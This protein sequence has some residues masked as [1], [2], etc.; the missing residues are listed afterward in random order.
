[1]SRPRIACVLVAS[2]ALGCAAGWLQLPAAQ[3]APAAKA[4]AKVDTRALE[5]QLRSKDPAA[6]KAGLQ[7]VR[8]AGKAAA[9]AAPAIDELLQAG[10][11]ADLALEAFQAAG[12]AGA[13]SSSKAL[14]PY[15]YHRDAKLRREALKAMSRTRGATAAFAMRRCLSDADAGVRGVAASGL[16]ALG[17]KESVPD[18]FLALERKVDEAAGSIGQLCNPEQCVQLLDRAGRIGLDVLAPGFDQILFRPSSEVNDE[19]KIKIVGRVR[20]MGTVEVSRFLKDVQGRWPAKG[21][22]KVKQAIDQAVIATEGG[23]EDKKE[24]AA[25]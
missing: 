19:L 15:T 24:G 3:A 9:P 14:D 10:L 4:P 11:P 16:G 5:A 13:E 2:A 7:A 23:A 8:E 20:E 21:S 1:M 22:K 12:A 6:I 17:V 25:Q 18:L